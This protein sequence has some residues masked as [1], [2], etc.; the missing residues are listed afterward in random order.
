MRQINESKNEKKR[1]YTI[2]K[3]YEEMEYTQKY[4]E[5]WNAT[6]SETFTN[7]YS[8]DIYYLYKNNKQ[9]VHQ[10]ENKY[11]SQFDLLD[12]YKYIK[13]KQKLDEPI[14]QPLKRITLY[15][16]D[17]NDYDCEF[18]QIEIISNTASK[19]KRKFIFQN[20][21]DITYFKY[22]KKSVNIDYKAKYNV[23]SNDLIITFNLDNEKLHLESYNNIQYITYNNL[24]IETNT[25]DG[26]KKISYKQDNNKKQTIEFTIELNKNNKITNKYIILKNYSI[27]NTLESTYEFYY[28]Q[29]LLNGALYFSKEH[30]KH[31]M[32]EDQELTNLAN[33]ILSTIN[34]DN[35]VFNTN[36]KELEKII[37]EIKE[38]TFNLIKSIKNDIPLYGLEKRLDITLSNLFAKPIKKD[39]SKK[40]ENYKSKDN[41][42]KIKN[43][44]KKLSKNKKNNKH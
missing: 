2:N 23:N 44:T 33:N 17:G 7:I 26:S 20:N 8:M 40:E 14:E 34:K 6:I 27:D 28:N 43:K 39:I 35:L 3:V 24:S 30:K 11:Y 13:D 36:P 15:D 19:I 21:G 42:Q 25:L 41:H 29:D 16:E 10:L 37:I 5:K 12:I 18:R 32:F 9:L 38:K 4:L 31:N 22:K 1:N